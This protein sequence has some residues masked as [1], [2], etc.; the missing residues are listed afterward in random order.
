[1]NKN[2]DDSSK[3]LGGR[4]FRHYIKQHS[5]KIG[6]AAIFMIL[7]AAATASNAL[8]IKPIM[9]DIFL[10]R[11]REL[12][13]IIPF[14]ILA[15]ALV[16]GTSVYFQSVI[17]KTI[18]QRVATD[19]QLDLYKHLL[20]SDIT[21]FNDQSSGKLISKFT[22][23]INII[24][25]SLTNV[26]VGIAKETMTLIFLVGV[27]FYQS[28]ELS[29]IAFI[30][31]PTAIYPIIR[32]GKN[33]RKVSHKTQEE[34]GEFTSTL[35]D[36]FQAVRMV[37]AYG[38]EKYEVK[39]AKDIV[40]SIYQLYLKAVR[41]E[42][43]A[44]PIMEALAGIAVAAVVWYGGYQVFQGETTQGALF[45]FIGAFLMAY[46]PMKSLTGINANLQEGLA[47]VKRFYETMDIEPS[48]ADDSTSAELELENA[49]IEFEDVV[50]KYDRADGNKPAI[51]GI[52]FH[53]PSGKR[54]ALVGESGGGKS[55]II[56]LILRFYD[57]NSGKISIGGHNTRNVTLASM[58]SK[59]SVVNQEAT[60]FD[61]TIRA[62]ICYGKKDATEEEMIEAAKSAAAHEFIS[63]QID[64]YDTLVGQ[65]GLR[66]SGGQRQRLAIARAMLRNSPILLLD[67]ATS[68]L[69]T[70]SEQKVQG[71]LDNLMKDRTTIVIAHRLSTV[72]NADIIYVVDKGR[73][74]ESGT[75]KKL[76]RKKGAY[77]K[78]YN[79]QFEK[80]C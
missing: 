63:A 21:L 18:G 23:D 39:R 14:V 66:L 59:I 6:I 9:D 22:N 15:I 57:P 1:M 31:F 17:M 78:L 55:T 25:R 4:L 56:N 45:S 13:N 76:L 70:V 33:M 58:R 42:S 49:D 71:A 44:S 74:T 27:M 52:S 50:F 77:Y 79:K 75:H 20:N 48:I 24:R 36:T 37:K 19:M 43:A 73:I 16:K 53:V 29:L 51:D 11:D 38:N 41:I 67:E 2:L 72:I 60:L 26:L 47:A 8:M 65:H 7:A 64:G 32:L 35:D 28:W 46:K 34:L 62:N 80:K 40:E 5:T 12:L 30:V 69:D 10:S 54:I 61:D 3:K 68:A